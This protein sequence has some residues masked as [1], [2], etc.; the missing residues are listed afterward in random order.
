MVERSKKWLDKL[1]AQVE[2][3][4]ER[5]TRQEAAIIAILAGASIKQVFKRF[6][7]P[8]RGPT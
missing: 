6:G 4:N 7:S 1:E 3:K 5:M 8:G 2:D